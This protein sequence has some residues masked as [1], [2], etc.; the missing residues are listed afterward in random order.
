MND[1]QLARYLRA[2]RRRLALPKALRD[3][4]MG[5]LR[6]SI[7]ERRDAGQ[8]DEEIFFALG[9]AKQAADELNRQMRAY[10][11]HK[12]P[13]RF[14]SLGAAAAALLALPVLLTRHLTGLP[15]SI[16]I[17]GGADGPTAIFVSSS[18]PIEQNWLDVIIACAVLLLGVAGFFLLRR[19]PSKEA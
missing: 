14:A 3:R 15:S 6:S 17:I 4:V 19:L 2:V 12:S 13:W 8:S 1:K 9:S 16:G 7:T 5:D 10:A 18:V 11:Y